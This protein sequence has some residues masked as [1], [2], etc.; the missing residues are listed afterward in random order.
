MSTAGIVI[1]G[2]EILSGKIQDTNGPFLMKELRELG[3]SVC[4]LTV[5]ADQKEEIAEVVSSFAQKYTWVFTSGGL[6]V[7]HDDVTIAA[8]AQVF[9]VPMIQHPDLMEKLEQASQRGLALQNAH[10]RLAQIPQG[11][12]LFK[13]APPVWPAFSLQN[14]FVLP[15][16]PSC[17]RENFLVI[18][19]T[20]RESPFFLK[21]IFVTQ[22]EELIADQLMLLARK[23]PQM[24]MGS[25]PVDMA[26][27]QRQEASS[28]QPKYKVKVTLESKDQNATEQAYQELIHLLGM[29]S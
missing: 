16:I 14:V 2:N 26:D 7:T 10:M 23:Y 25:Y 22:E 19:E 6:G 13:V 29:K 1:I 24:M 5:L 18:K 4:Q 9:S 15:G 21:Q 8:I 28:I 20:F 27:F 11:A 17:F 3:V 12:H